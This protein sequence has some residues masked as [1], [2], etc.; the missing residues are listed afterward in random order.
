M[1]APYF[2]ELAAHVYVAAYSG[3]TY[4]KLAAELQGAG[5]SAAYLK[6][7]LDLHADAE[8]LL[9]RM[10]AESPENK[11]LEHNIHAAAMELEMWLQT[12][13]FRGRKAGKRTD[14]S[15]GLVKLLIGSDLHAHD[16][17]ISVA[18]QAL[19]AVGYLRVL[20]PEHVSAFE[21][22]GS[23]RDLIMRGNTLTKKLYKVADNFVTPSSMVPR[24]HPIF[25]QFDALNAQMSA[26]LLQL[27]EASQRITEVRTLG[28][29]GFVPHDRGLPVGGAAFNVTL[30]ERGQG[31][32]PVPGTAERTSGWSVGRQ[33]NKENLGRP[34]WLPVEYGSVEGD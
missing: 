17:H 30:H 10:S 5:L 19:R 23:L 28:I 26:W 15:E 29:I 2:Y 9:S 33:G 25:A 18:A 27:F 6:Q 21:R 14:F 16:H 32:P 1:T 12:V 13:K 22:D 7:G 3:H 31:A 8:A 11:T 24:S 20:K 34:A 4:K